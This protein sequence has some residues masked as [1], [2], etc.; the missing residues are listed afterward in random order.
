MIG[1]FK[2]FLQK[3]QKV[4]LLTG[5]LTKTIFGTWQGQKEKFYPEAFFSANVQGPRAFSSRKIRQK[6]VASCACGLCNTSNGGGGRL[7]KRFECFPPQMSTVTSIPSISG[8]RQKKQEQFFFAN[9]DFLMHLDCR[10]M[11]NNKIKK[12]V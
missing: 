11:A 1:Q 2:N 9:C 7:R 3:A 6:A 5:N 12:C 10:N 8:R 4:P